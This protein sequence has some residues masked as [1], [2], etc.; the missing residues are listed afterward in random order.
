LA[1]VGGGASPHQG[2]DQP[3]ARNGLVAMQQ[4]QDQDAALPALAECDRA[5]AFGDLER[6]Q[7]AKEHAS[8][9]LSRP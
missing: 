2:V 5:I 9:L 3:I 7:Q 1:A 4:Q 6:S 8:N